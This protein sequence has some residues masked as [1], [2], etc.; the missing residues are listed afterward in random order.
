M[1]QS[2]R[3]D[4]VNTRK[5]LDEID[6]DLK[7]TDDVVRSDDIKSSI[8][9]LLS[10]FRIIQKQFLLELIGSKIIISLLSIASYIEISLPNRF[11]KRLQNGEKVFAVHK[12]NEEFKYGEVSFFSN[13]LFFYSLSSSQSS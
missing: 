5:I 4:T 13:Q 1:S 6:E 2:E 7:K 3:I 8:S 12:I 9:I 11:N 10:S